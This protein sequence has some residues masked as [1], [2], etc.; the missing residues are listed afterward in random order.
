M[1]QSIFEQ[2]SAQIETSRNEAIELMKSI[3]PIK[4]LGPLNGGVGETEKAEFIIQYLKKIGFENISEY[5]AKDPKLPN[6]VRPNIMALLPGKNK[7]KTVWI[8]AHLD[9]VPAGDLSKWETDPFEAVV[10]EGKIYGRGTEDNNQG[11]VSAIIAAKAFLDLGIAPAYNIG[12]ALVA[13]EET[14]SVYGLEHMMKNHRH[15]FSPN[16]LI[17]VPDAGEPDASMI[18]VAEKSIIWMKFK[19]TGKQVHAST[20]N[21]GIN[22]F[23]AASH[24]VVALEELS[25][26]YNAKDT[27]FDVPQSIFTPTKKEANVGNINT[28]P[29]EDV[30]YLDCRI[31]PIYNI[32][33]VMQKTREIANKIEAQ[34]NVRI[35]ISTEQKEQAA[36]A[37]PVDAEVVALLKSAIKDVYQINAKPMGIGGGTVAALFRRAGFNAAVWSTLDDLAHQPNEYCVIDNM[38]NDAK[39]FAHILSA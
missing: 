3:I 9:V 37:T 13:D 7:K 19:T 21:K 2:I 35:E 17:I 39:V 26:I 14:G 12:L 38:I 5:P 33:E 6:G 16:D 1:A 29:G 32:E 28:M 24:L 23:R 15:L 11:M 20:P 36:P 31:L 4:A 22:A 27:V 8:L 10:K 25:E 34:F 30:F 18:E